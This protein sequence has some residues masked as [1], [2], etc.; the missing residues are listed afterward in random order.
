MKNLIGKL[1]TNI[2][3]ELAAVLLIGIS[4]LGFSALGVPL[5]FIYVV[6][7]MINFKE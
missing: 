1:F 6:L 3:A 7:W 2:W 5:L 4:C